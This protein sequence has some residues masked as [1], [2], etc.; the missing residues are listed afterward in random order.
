[1]KSVI[2]QIVIILLLCIAIF[3]LLAVIFYENMPISIVV[4][5]NV[6]SYVTPSEIKEEIAKDIAEYPKQF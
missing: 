1:M 3:L 2:K 5:S 6:A 4:P